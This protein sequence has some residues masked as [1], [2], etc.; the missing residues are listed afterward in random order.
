MSRY[1]KSISAFLGLIG[2]WGATAGAD[3][4]YDQIELWGLTGV[5]VGT[6]AVFQLP[7]RPPAGEPSD[8]EISEQGAVEP[9]SLVLG[10]LIALLI[11]FLLVHY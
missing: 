11:V 8:P 1:I 10:A 9:G 3:G 4:H 5:L 7:N 2:T 6:L